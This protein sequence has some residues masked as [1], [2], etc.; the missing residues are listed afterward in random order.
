MARHPYG[1]INKPLWNL[2]NLQGNVEHDLMQSLIMEYTD[3]SGI[4]IEYYTRSAS[5][6]FD[7]LYGENDSVKFDDPKTSKILYDVDVEPNIMTAF[8][9]FGNDSITIQMPQSTFYR[10]VSK[11]VEPR[12][13]DVIHI[14]W[15]DRNFEISHVDYDDKIFQ[16]KKFIWLMILK[17]YRFSEQSDSASDISLSKPISAY[18][19]NEFIEEQS[20]AIDDYSG[21]IDSKIYGF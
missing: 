2:H 11:T 10:D 19:D 17:P 16:L 5:A 4:E 18:G 14:K 12:I 1:G 7:V 9:M 3:I 21:G 20:D 15:N 8:G 6:S 13:G